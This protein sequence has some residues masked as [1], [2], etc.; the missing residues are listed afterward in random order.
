LIKFF[1]PDHLRKHFEHFL[2]KENLIL[3]NESFCYS[4]VRKEDIIKIQQITKDLL[5][6]QLPLIVNSK[7]SQEKIQEISNSVLVEFGFTW[8]LTNYPDG[9]P[10]LKSLEDEALTLAKWREQI[11]YLN[12]IEETL[13]KVLI[14]LQQNHSNGEDSTLDLIELDPLE[15]NQ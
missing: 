3:N 6:S 13:F 4:H 5:F 11:L 7:I 14:Q 12:I 1:N 2:P 10:L 9:K 15:L 8:I